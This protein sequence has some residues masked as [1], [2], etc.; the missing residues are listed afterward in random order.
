MPSWK[1]NTNAVLKRANTRLRKLRSCNV[2]QELLQMFYSSV[3]SSVLT[4]GLLSWGGNISRRDVETLDKIIKKASGVV[5]RT[6][7]NL[8]TLQQTCDT[9]TA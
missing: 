3:L 8:D 1:Q 4:F 7:D 5:G 9:K 2:R 6:Q